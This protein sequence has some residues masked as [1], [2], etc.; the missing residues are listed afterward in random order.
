MA[1]LLTLL[2]PV[3]SL[4][5]PANSNNESLRKSPPI[6]MGERSPAYISLPNAAALP[7]LFSK[8]YNIIDTKK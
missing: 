7:K 2:V 6:N 1:I 5:L 3:E 4:K 8:F